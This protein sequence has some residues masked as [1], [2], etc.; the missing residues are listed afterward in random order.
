MRDSL[1]YCESRPAPDSAGADVLSNVRRAHGLRPLAP[2]DRRGASIN[3][4]AESN[5]LHMPGGNAD[6]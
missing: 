6:E 5:K 4:V 2:V 1:C 3:S